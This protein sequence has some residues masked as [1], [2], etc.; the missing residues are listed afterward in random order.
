MDTYYGCLRTFWREL[1]VRTVEM[2][3]PLQELADAVWADLKRERAKPLH[4]CQSTSSDVSFLARSFPVPE[5]RNA[6]IRCP[7]ITNFVMFTARQRARV[8]HPR[9]I[10]LARSYPPKTALEAR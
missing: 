1:G 8:S 3:P 5:D 6:L 9:L 2:Y 7:H 10:A 4:R